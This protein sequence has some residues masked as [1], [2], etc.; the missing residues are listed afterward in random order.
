VLYLLNS[1]LLQGR[2]M[3]LSRDAQRRIQRDLGREENSAPTPVSHGELSS[4]LTQLMYDVQ[5]HPPFSTAERN[6]YRTLLSE[7]SLFGSTWLCSKTLQSIFGPKKASDS[8]LFLLTHTVDWAIQAILFDQLKAL[9]P[10]SKAAR[11]LLKSLTSSPSESEDAGV[12]YGTKLLT[13]LMRMSHGF[14]DP[15]RAVGSSSRGTGRAQSQSDARH[16]PAVASS[17]FEELLQ[18]LAYGLR[19]NPDGFREAFLFQDDEDDLE[20]EPTGSP[21]AS[22]TGPGGR[23]LSPV[24]GQMIASAEIS[25]REGV[26]IKAESMG[27]QIPRAFLEHQTGPG[28]S[29]RG[30]SS[31]PSSGSNL[32]PVYHLRHSIE[33]ILN[34]SQAQE[35]RSARQYMLFRMLFECATFTR[36]DSGVDP[37]DIVEEIVVAVATSKHRPSTN[38][39]HHQDA[40][41]TDSTSSSSVSQLL[42]AFLDYCVDHVDFEALRWF[43]RLL[44]T[45]LADRGNPEKSGVVDQLA[46]LLSIA[47]GLQRILEDRQTE[48]TLESHSSTEWDL[49]RTMQRFGRTAL[50]RAFAKFRDSHPDLDL[51]K[52]CQWFNP[53][54]GVSSAPGGETLGRRLVQRNTPPQPASTSTPSKRGSKATASYLQEG[55][56]ETKPSSVLGV[57]RSPYWNHLGPATRILLLD[58]EPEL[59]ESITED[60]LLNSD[61]RRASS[62][63]NRSLI[64]LHLAAKKLSRPSSPLVSAGGGAETVFG[65]M[66]ASLAWSVHRCMCKPGGVEPEDALALTLA[67]CKEVYYFCYNCCNSAPLDQTSSEFFWL[68]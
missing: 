18:R 65:W 8:V 4:M 41:V 64:G 13:G 57:L 20:K 42:K 39:E 29:H 67:R 2:P 14:V 60:S 46:T 33:S 23:T 38:D 35:E 49:H 27:E 58:T 51:E 26:I 63:Q 1:M 48:E 40:P 36:R 32:I 55:L 12:L 61:N 9:L 25:D 56:V 5:L 34:S 30:S 47:Q 22:G 16:R 59:W 53:I 6:V 62:T 7:V 3:K 17:T 50:A 66:C 52:S 43:I 15:S 28:N 11:R 21:A 24:D 31:S 37:T 10:D 68:P 54:E 19:F 44:L 45:T